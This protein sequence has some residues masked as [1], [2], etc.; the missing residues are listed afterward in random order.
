MRAADPVLNRLRGLWSGDRT[1]LAHKPSFEE[2]IYMGLPP[3]A[4]LRPGK[5]QDVRRLRAEYYHAPPSQRRQEVLCGPSGLRSGPLRSAQYVPPVE[6]VDVVLPV[7]L[8]S[9]A[10][11][12]IGE[13]PPE[14]PASAALGSRIESH[15]GPL[16]VGIVHS[17]YHGAFVSHVSTPLARF[18]ICLT[19]T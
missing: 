15:V 3:L 14:V 6:G 13:H 18:I 4:H 17:D 7:Y 11:T 10:S 5:T 19:V 12:R 1:H 8:V 16:S 9:S 2:Y